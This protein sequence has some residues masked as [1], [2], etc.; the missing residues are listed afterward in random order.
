MGKGGGT[1]TVK[2]SLC[3]LLSKVPKDTCFQNA[4]TRV[5]N[6]SGRSLG[7]QAGLGVGGPAVSF[8]LRGVLLEW[9]ELQ[10]VCIVDLNA[11]KI[12]GRWL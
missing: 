11:T 9:G 10:F 7:A 12:G 4:L 5:N 2:C 3:Q 6:A 1:L 8:F